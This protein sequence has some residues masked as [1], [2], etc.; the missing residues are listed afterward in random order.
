M[1]TKE[2]VKCPCCSPVEQYGD[3]ATIRLDLDWIRRDLEE[4]GLT[5]APYLKHLLPEGHPYR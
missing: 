5:Q 4:R 3:V 2:T 1:D